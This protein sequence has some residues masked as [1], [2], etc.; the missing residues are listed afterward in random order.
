MLV[1]VNQLAYDAGLTGR[2]I[3]PV[4]IRDPAVVVDARQVKRPGGIIEVEP[5]GAICVETE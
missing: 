5:N 3:N 1:T 4:E 2:G